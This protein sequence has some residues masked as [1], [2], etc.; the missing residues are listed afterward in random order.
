MRR[1]FP[2]CHFRG[3]VLSKVCDVQQQTEAF[4]RA[5]RRLTSTVTIITTAHHGRRH[6][7]LATAVC[8]I[9]VSP[10]SL[11]VSIATSASIHDPLVARG[12]YC[13]NLLASDH[14]DLVRPFSGALKGEE[15]FSVGDWVSG[16]FGLPYLRDAQASLFCTVG[17]IVPFANH[18]I[19]IG[20]VDD[21]GVRDEISPLLYE[22]GRLAVAR[23]LT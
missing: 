5:M 15:R 17:S 14:H 11:L 8:S 20:C 4:K 18:S 13:V 21:V 23:A 1:Q 19:I 7:M 10:P 2:V 3:A 9:G 22:D 12:G 16:P 6:G